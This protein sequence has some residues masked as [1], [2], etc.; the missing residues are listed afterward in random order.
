M[1]E[2]PPKK[3]IRDY[4]LPEFDQPSIYSLS[5]DEL[6]EQAVEWGEADY[7]GEQIFEWLYIHRVNHLDE[8]LNLPKTLR[9]KLAGNYNMDSLETVVRQE[10]KDGTVKFLRSVERRVG[11]DGSNRLSA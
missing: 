1:I 3:E 11:G 9:E 10:S 5:K 2:R 6:K 8:M 4:K 7:R